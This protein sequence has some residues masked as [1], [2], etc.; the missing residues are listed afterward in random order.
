MKTKTSTFCLALLFVSLMLFPGSTS[1]QKNKSSTRKPKSAPKNKAASTPTS[2][3]NTTLAG[4]Y[5]LIDSAAATNKIASAIE[6]SVK[7]M[8]LEGKARRKLRETNLPAPQQITIWY[9]AA[10]FSIQTDQSGLIQTPPDGRAIKWTSKY[11]ETYDVSTRWVGANLE[12]TFKS[13][14]G[15]RV[16]TY[17]LSSDGK[18][19]IMK[20]TGKTEGWLTPSFKHP[21]NYQL[22][23]RRN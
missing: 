17:S 19:M 3:P 22:E 18:T 4:S 7:G 14:Q 15:R 11:K 10:D 20:V 2:T 21:F 5:T 6:Y 8:W 23:Y 1:A 13:S 16:N 12:R 9:S